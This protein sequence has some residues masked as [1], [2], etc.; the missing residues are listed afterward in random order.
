[1]LD[2]IRVDL[3]KLRDPPTVKINSTQDVVNFIKEMEDYDRENFRVLA[4]DVKNRIIAVQTIAIGS[5]NAAIIH[6]REVLKGVLLANAHAVLLV[7]NHPSGLSQPSNEDG[8][9]QV[10]G[11]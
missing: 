7:H 6:P 2:T 8:F 5:L 3:K 9:C 10:F 4:L 1:M 11:G